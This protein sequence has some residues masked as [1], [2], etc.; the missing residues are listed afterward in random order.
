MEQGKQNVMVATLAVTLAMV[1][2]PV[3]AQPPA[4]QGQ[5]TT[6]QQSIPDAP[7]PQTLPSLTPLTP[8]G[9]ALPDAPPPSA[10]PATA[11]TENG[12]VAP[13]TSLTSAPAPTAEAQQEATKDAEQG[14]VPDMHHA[15]DIHVYSNFVNVPFTVKDSH[16]HLVP[17]LT[18]RDVRVYE[19]GVRQQM[20]LFTVDPFPLSVSV[21]IDQSVPFD[22]MTKINNSLSSLQGAFSKYDEVAVFTYNNGVKEQTTF[23]AAQG[24]RLGAVLDYSK[25]K[26]R[27]FAPMMGGPMDHNITKNGTELDPNTSPN[28]GRSVN[29]G[30]ETAEIES[31][32]LLDAILAA[33]QETTHAPKERRRI[34]YVISDGKEYG[35]VAK[36]KDVIKYLQT[37]N[38]EVYATLVRDA[39][40][41]GLGFLDR[42]HLPLMMRDDIMPRIVS[43]TGGEIDPEYRQG[44]I[45]KSFARITEEVRTQYTVGYY[46]RLSPLNESKRS[47]EVRVLRPGL[48]IISKDAYYPNAHDSMPTPPTPVPATTAT[49]Q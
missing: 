14:P 9:P 17:G 42:M 33:A 44:Q 39:S 6:Q 18:W 26:G 16:G 21:V 43:A 34:V 30:F 20:R 4:P 7:K 12:G 8:V 23:T 35:S 48:T 24:A 49:K 22:V 36:E 10:A 5:Q 19:N 11:T 28:R 47:V 31:H 3:A 15:S 38:V 25:G 46:T 45:E 1:C 40:I 32:T 27:E 29:G 37:N 41:A 2:G 13:G